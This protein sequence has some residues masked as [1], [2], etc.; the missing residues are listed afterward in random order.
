MLVGENNNSQTPINIAAYKGNLEVVRFLL[1]KG[2]DCTIKNDW[3]YVPATNAK[4][5]GHT[6]V[7]ELLPKSA[8]CCCLQ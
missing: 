3:G 5:Q 6:A 1:S 7:V 4:A 8:L 2:A